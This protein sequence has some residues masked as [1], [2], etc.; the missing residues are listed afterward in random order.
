MPMHTF[1]M[2]VLAGAEVVWQKPAGQAKGVLFVAHG[3]S[4][5]A[6]DW[7]HKAD[8]CPLCIGE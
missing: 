1:A 5:G 4:H 6:I 2:Q 8:G 3:C 7:W